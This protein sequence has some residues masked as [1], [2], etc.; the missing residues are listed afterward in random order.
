MPSDASP[1]A[2]E[3]RLALLRAEG[4]PRPD[5]YDHFPIVICDG[6]MEVLRVTLSKPSKAFFGRIQESGFPLQTSDAERYRQY[7]AAW[8]GD[9]DWMI[10]QLNEIFPRLEAWKLPSENAGVPS[11]WEAVLS[12]VARANNLETKVLFH[13]T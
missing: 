12:E 1:S 5:E 13:S 9:S 7:R 3:R 8:H 11:F 6:E 2:Y 10:R 4:L